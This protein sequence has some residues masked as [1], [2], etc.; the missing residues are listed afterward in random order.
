MIV[1]YHVST[2]EYFV[3]AGNW[4]KI[5]SLFYIFWDLPYLD[6]LWFEHCV[7]LAALWDQ[8]PWFHLSK[9]VYCTAVRGNVTI[10]AQHHALINFISYGL[11]SEHEKLTESPEQ[12]RF[13]QQQGLFCLVCVQDAAQVLLAA[14]IFDIIST[15]YAYPNLLLPRP[16]SSDM[17]RETASV[18]PQVPQLFD[19]IQWLLLLAMHGLALP[20]P[21]R[22][23]NQDLG[24]VGPRLEPEAWL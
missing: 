3:L 23:K 16:S 4:P 11:P 24:L 1:L 14:T 5:T 20:R 21:N 10:C 7:L 17:Q 9:N 19:C 12:S 2:V 6:C 15:N 13:P 18:P 22:L 8:L